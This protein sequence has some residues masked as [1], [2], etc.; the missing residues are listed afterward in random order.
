[1]G[2]SK[3]IGADGHPIPEVQGVVTAHIKPILLRDVRLHRL[4]VPEKPPVP[5]E[6]MADVSHPITKALMQQ[7]P[8][9]LNPD[10]AL[11]REMLL[12]P[13]RG[14]A[15]SSSKQIDVDSWVGLVD[16]EIEHRKLEG[17]QA[18]QHMMGLFS[19]NGLRARQDQR[20]D[21]AIKGCPR[22]AGGTD[23]HTCGL[24]PNEP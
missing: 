10:L 22:C 6:V 18:F 14:G 1:M 21:N 19:K 2:E 17:A 7:L 13:E 9:M 4:I 16:L 15:Y 20:A 3:R 23:R 12:D 24:P 5:S 11:L 8:K